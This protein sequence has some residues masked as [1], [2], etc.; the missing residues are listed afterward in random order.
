M[1]KRTPVTYSAALLVLLSLFTAAS[2]MFGETPSP[3]Y[4]TGTDG[5]VVDISQTKQTYYDGEYLKL[6]LRIQNKGAYDNPKGKIAISGFDKNIIKINDEALYLPDLKGI[7][8]YLPEGEETLIDIPE[9]GPVSLQIG[10]K[11]ETTIQTNICYEYETIANPVVCLI[12]N[13]GDYEQQ[14]VCEP[15]VV[16]LS[17]QGAPVAVTQVQTQ[18]GR[19][20]ATFYI[21]LENKGNGR[22]YKSED[23]E[24]FDHCPYRLTNNDLDYVQVSVK[25][26]GLGEP[27][28]TPSGLV[29][30]V[31]NVG[32]LQCKFTLR[33]DAAFKTPMLV[34][35][36]YG[37]LETQENA[38][39]IQKSGG[40]G[41]TNPEG[42]Y[43]PMGGPAPGCPCSKK[44]LDAQ[45]SCVC[46]QI[47]GKLYACDGG[48][49]ALAYE[50]GQAVTYEVH[51][52]QQGSNAITSCGTTATPTDA[53]PYVGT[54]IMRNSLTS[55]AIYGRTKQDT[56]VS[57]TCHFLPKQVK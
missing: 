8:P 34:T 48:V 45:G 29:K 39:T 57:S 43:I 12:S 51:G 19:N 10:E 44:T 20:E 42:T 32:L 1:K 11:Y 46:A 26:N 24:A 2:C 13:Y 54:L 27:E 9:F 14:E 3:D 47:D 30:L 18:L 25:I 38:L 6:A 55:V 52:Y 15:D 49:Y 7:D 5:V 37:Y 16:A 36:H 23:L 50:S 17:S 33:E 21:T 41:L 35:L 53:C 40:T 22:V 31:N 28:C 56:I 4:R